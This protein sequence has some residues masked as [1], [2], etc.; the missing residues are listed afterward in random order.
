VSLQERDLAEVRAD[1]IAAG[2]KRPELH[3]AT[4]SRLKMRVHDLR[5]T[6]ITTS[7]ATGITPVARSRDAREPFV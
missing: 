3:E 7:L 6:M 2:V 5:A 4:K 1:L